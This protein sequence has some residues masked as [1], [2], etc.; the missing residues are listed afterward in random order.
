MIET[1]LLG[2]L[3]GCLLVGGLRFQMVAQG[4][5]QRAHEGLLGFASHRHRLQRSRQAFGE[6]GGEFG[7]EQIPP[8]CGL[9][10][11]HLAFLP[12]QL[13]PENP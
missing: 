7:N 5:A 11:L 2:D 1:Q 4:L 10:I 12:L 8:E 3:I 13:Q 6:I 9:Q